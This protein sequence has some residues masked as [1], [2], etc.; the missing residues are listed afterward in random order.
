[1][2]KY[3]YRLKNKKALK[4]HLEIQHR[5]KNNI[6]GKIKEMSYGFTNKRSSDTFYLYCKA[7]IDARY[8]AVESTVVFDGDIKI[9]DDDYFR[10]K[11]EQSHR[12]NIAFINDL[13]VY[14]QFKNEFC[15]KDSLFLGGF[16][17]TK[18]SHWVNPNGV[19]DTDDIFVNVHEM[20]CGVYE[21]FTGDCV[22][23]VKCWD[24]ITMFCIK[25]MYIRDGFL[26]IVTHDDGI[27]SYDADKVRL[28]EPSI[29]D[30]IDLIA[31]E[32]INVADVQRH[33][34][35]IITEIKK[36]NIELLID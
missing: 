4:N 32:N 17:T 8:A 34:N 20:S 6:L 3:Y 9:L 22:V 28:S 31:G 25:D 19:M 33:R 1:M 23:N 13:D 11:I 29:I 24:D 16:E 15:T 30:K 5:C 10:R 2:K 35:A 21:N 27:I 7:I 14:K 18:P 12:Y 26:Y 36:H